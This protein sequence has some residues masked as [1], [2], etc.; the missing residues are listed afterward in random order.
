MLHA[1]QALSPASCHPDYWSSPSAGRHRGCS[2]E[3]QTR[4]EES[5]QVG[6]DSA[7]HCLYTILIVM[8]IPLDD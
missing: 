7:L 1:A 8:Y 6:A 4:R 5:G 2:L 3:G